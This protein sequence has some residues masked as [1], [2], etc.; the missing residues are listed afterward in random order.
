MENKYKVIKPFSY[1]EVGDE[2]ELTEDGMYTCEATDGA[3]AEDA[4]GGVYESYSSYSYTVSP[5]VMDKLIKDGFVANA[6]VENKKFVNVFDEIDR[7]QET[8]TRELASLEDEMKDAP[9]CM[10]IEKQTVLENLNTLL[11][12]L[13][14]LK[15]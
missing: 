8:Y 11:E 15:N 4:E 2:F 1:M 7:L 5:A 13:K 14:T 6:A 3:S 10:K 12:H 9:A